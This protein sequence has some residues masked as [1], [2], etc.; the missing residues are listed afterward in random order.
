MDRNQVSFKERLADT[1]PI[2]M[3]GAMGTEL[4]R[5]GRKIGAADWVS[6]TLGSADEVR[7]I[8]LSYVKAGARIHIANTFATARHV[9]AEIGIADQFD[10]I[11]RNAVR[12][13]RETAESAG[14]SPQWVAG[15]I[16]T[17]VIGSDRSNLPRGSVLEAQV[18][19]QGDI[20][21]DAG[22]DLLVLE[23]LFDIETTVVM[24]KAA[25]STGLPVSIG[26]TCRL[27]PQRN[28]CLRGEHTAREDYTLPL[29]H[30]LP[31]IIDQAE[32]GH[33]W[34]MTIMHSDLEAT[35]AA[36]DLVTDCWDGPIGVYPNSGSLIPPDAWDHDSVC[37]PPAFVASSENWSAKGAN[38]IGGCCGIGP[39]H[40]EALADAFS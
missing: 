6:T 10:A 3:D 40:I 39:R 18:V 13:C 20:L 7:D 1:Q 19:E 2:V 21:A 29:K 5:L 24:M 22:C 35:D 26:L 37:S 36:L 14:H 12:L 31:A 4:T 32:D 28:V 25:A 8:H 17:Y 27:D 11:N 9:L 33:T 16:S 38:I 15:S 30:A 34:I 23:M